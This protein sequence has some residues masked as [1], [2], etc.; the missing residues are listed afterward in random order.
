MSLRAEAAATDPRRRPW[1]CN[2]QPARDPEGR[3]PAGRP[4]SAH[5]NHRIE[6]SYRMT[7]LVAPSV[8]SGLATTTAAVPPL[9]HRVAAVRSSI[10]ACR[11][12]VRAF[13]RR[14]RSIRWSRS[15]RCTCSSATAASSCSCAS[16]SSRRTSSPSTHTSRRTRHPGSIMRG[17]TRTQMIERFGLTSQPSV[18]EVASNDGYL[19]QY[20]VAAWH[21]GARHRAG[22]Q[23]RRGAHGRAASTRW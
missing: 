4:V 20:F 16:T 11:H 7:T 5:V 18:V 14:Q 19:L 22:C 3:P 10:S 17:G 12:S 15:I 21:S 6:A 1:A 2:R 8:E 9:R 13:F 23:R